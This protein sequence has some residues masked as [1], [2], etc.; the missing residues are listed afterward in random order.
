MV[1]GIFGSSGILTLLVLIITIGR[2]LL[3]KTCAFNR[4]TIN[5]NGSKRM[6][7]FIYYNRF[8]ETESVFTLQLCLLIQ[9]AGIGVPDHMKL[10][11]FGIKQG[12]KLVDIDFMFGRNKNCR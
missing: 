7:P 5:K 9:K 12:A 8:Y 11:N 2:L 6:T 4:L 3:V 1:P 10:F